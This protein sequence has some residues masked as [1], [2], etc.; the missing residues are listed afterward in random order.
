MSDYNHDLGGS[1]NSESSHHRPGA[2]R[3]ALAKVKNATGATHDP[4]ASYVDYQDEK[5]HPHPKV[6]DMVNTVGYSLIQEVMQ[7]LKGPDGEDAMEVIFTT[8]SRVA[9]RLA[10]TEEARRAARIAAHEATAG[11][12]DGG[13]R[14]VKEALANIPPHFVTVVSILIG[15]YVVLLSAAMLLSLWR[16]ALFGL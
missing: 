4:K 11:T 7:Y 15:S 12:Y 5:P 1:E 10:V 9:A 14:K 6:E 3:R 2:A 16:F 8:Q 13:E